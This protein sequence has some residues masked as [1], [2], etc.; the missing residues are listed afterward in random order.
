MGLRL[1]IRRIELRKKQKDVASEVGISQQYLAHLENGQAC[2]PNLDIM[3]KLTAA[4][5]CTAQELF[6]QD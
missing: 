5:Q 1:K 3:K 6:F 4:L 2:N